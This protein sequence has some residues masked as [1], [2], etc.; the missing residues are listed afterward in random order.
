MITSRVNG[1]AGPNHSRS[2]GI[3]C[4]LLCSSVLAS[5][6]ALWAP[7]AQAQNTQAVSE[8]VEQGH[9]NS[10][11][12]S[13]RIPVG[14]EVLSVDQTDIQATYPVDLTANNEQR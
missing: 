7:A 14:S 4:G 12:N 6:V 13:R 11:E 8:R 9:S 2:S 1:R 3:A 10:H 5:I